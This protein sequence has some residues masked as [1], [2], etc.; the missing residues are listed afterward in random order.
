MSFPWNRVNPHRSPQGEST[1]QDGPMALRTTDE[2]GSECCSVMEWISVA[3]ATSTTSPDAKAGR[4]PCM[5]LHTRELDESAHEAKQMTTAQAVGAVSHEAAEW[6]AIDWPAINRNVRPLCHTKITRI[7]GWRL[8]YCVSRVM[9]GSTG[10]TN[11]VLLHPECH[12]RVHRQ[13]LF[14]LKPRLLT[15]G[16]RRA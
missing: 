12:D 7:T 4:L 13:R 15:R 11:R 8:H 1:S 2:G 3:S 14:V 6:Y 9:G 16:V 5:V 10:A